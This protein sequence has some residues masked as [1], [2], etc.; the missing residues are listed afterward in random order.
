MDHDPLLDGVGQRLRSLRQQH[1]LSLAGL[2][3]MTSI[4]TS[5]LS[6]L[7]SGGRKPTLELLLGLARAY[8][9]SLDDLVGVPR[10]AT[11]AYGCG[12][13]AAMAARSSRYPSS[14]AGHGHTR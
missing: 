12:R 3:A 5:T 8:Q 14:R 9:V 6:R 4:S 7:E 2:S 10:R 1:R 11:R 13:S